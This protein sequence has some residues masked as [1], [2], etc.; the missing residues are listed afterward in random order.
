MNNYNIGDKVNV[1]FT[2]EKE[3]WIYGYIIDTG[4]NVRLLKSEIETLSSD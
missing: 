2:T 1:K 3:K 4:K